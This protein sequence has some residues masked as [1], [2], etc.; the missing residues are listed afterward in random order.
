MNLNTHLDSSGRPALST[1]ITEI[2]GSR[3]ETV[4]IGLDNYM[5][6]LNAQKTTEVRPRT[7]GSLSYYEEL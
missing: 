4:V 3:T 5:T 2:H 7:L 6:F 1:R